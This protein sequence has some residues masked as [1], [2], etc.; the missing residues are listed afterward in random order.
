M[1]ISFAILDDDTCIVDPTNI[2]ELASDNYITFAVA[3]DRKVCQIL[4]P[5]KEPIS[6]EAI[7]R[8]SQ[9]AVMRYFD[10]CTILKKSLKNIADLDLP[11]MDVPA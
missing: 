3:Q 2:E 8:C 7:Y 11:K 1:L 10:I 9:I 4:K 5:G 6:P